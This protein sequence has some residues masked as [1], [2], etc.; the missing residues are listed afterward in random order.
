[1]FYNLFYEYKGR[2]K[3]FYITII[4]YIRSYRELDKIL[5][6]PM[7]VKYIIKIFQIFLE[8]Y[9]LYIYYT[10]IPVFNNKNIK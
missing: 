2:G 6:F 7:Y 9:I 4:H 8:Y 10:F 3:F 1:M 5:V